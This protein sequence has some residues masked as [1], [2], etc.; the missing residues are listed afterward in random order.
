MIDLK[1]ASIIVKNLD[2]TYSSANQKTLNDISFDI[3]SGSILGLLGPNGAGKSTLIKCL[4]GLIKPDSGFIEMDFHKSSIGYLPEKMEVYE[5]LTG[6]DFIKMIGCLRNLSNE[7]INKQI[8]YFNNLL[9][10]PNL[11]NLISSYSKGNKEKILFLSAVIHEPKLLILDEPFTGLDPSAIF[12]AKNFIK[13]YAKKGNT[14]I[15]CTHLLEMVSQLCDSI[16]I[17]KNGRIL[18]KHSID[19]LG[20][21]NFDFDFLEKFYLSEVNYG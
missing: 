3:N 16:V 6:Y 15:L 21:S 11:N 19:T 12:E 14:I 8:D 7:Q 2:K 17:I 18:S 13:N 20:N 9:V 5:F 10:L 4:M 1:N